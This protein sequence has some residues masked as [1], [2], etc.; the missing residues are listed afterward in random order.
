MLGGLKVSINIKDKEEGKK[1]KQSIETNSTTS[2]IIK[3][4]K[5]S[6]KRIQD[7]I[8]I[9][10]DKVENSYIK[11][12]FTK[13]NITYIILF[14]CDIILVIYSARKNIVNY[15]MIL[16]QDV[17]VSKT[18]YLL[19]GRNYINLFIIGFF[20]IYICLVNRFFL[21]R[22]NTKK[23][24][25]SVFFLVVFFNIILFFLFTKRVY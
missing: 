21:H 20:Y 23:F 6:T 2:K 1:I 19:V 24:L 17:F 12:L 13:V 5:I 7:Q 4:R 9:K 8:V 11:K 22:R 15:V 25:I 10:N 18:K 3:G 14:L 16:D